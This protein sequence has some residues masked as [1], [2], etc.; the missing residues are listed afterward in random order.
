[1]TTSPLTISRAAPAA[2]SASRALLAG[3][4]VAGPAFIAVGLAQALTR[5]GLADHC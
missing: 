5:D 4:A 2:G 3:G 1:M